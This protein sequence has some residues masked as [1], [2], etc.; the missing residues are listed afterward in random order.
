MDSIVASDG[1]MIVNVKKWRLMR[2]GTSFLPPPGRSMAA[3]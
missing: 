2:F 3:T 1:V